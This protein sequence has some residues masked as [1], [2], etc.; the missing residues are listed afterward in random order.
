MFR[1]N[2]NLSFAAMRRF[3]GG[4]CAWR[5]VKKMKALHLIL[6]LSICILPSCSFDRT[7]A[8]IHQK[9]V[10]EIAADI[11]LTGTSSRLRKQPENYKTLLSP[12]E[13]VRWDQKPV[14]GITDEAVITFYRM[15]GNKPILCLGMNLHEDMQSYI[16]DKAA[17]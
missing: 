8:E 6:I 15:P 4:G 16:F 14:N 1:F 12:V 7:P 17:K 10:P 9:L 3:P 11:L 5:S 13:T 2:Y